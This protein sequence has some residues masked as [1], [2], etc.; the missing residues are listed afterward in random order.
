MTYSEI[1]QDACPG[2]ISDKGKGGTNPPIFTSKPIIPYT[3]SLCRIRHC[4][5]QLE[6]FVE[7][8]EPANKLSE[9]INVLTKL[10]KKCFSCTSLYQLY[11]EGLNLLKRLGGRSELEKFWS[12]LSDY[13]FKDTRSKLITEKGWPIVLITGSSFAQ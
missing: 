11:S 3:N 8:Q 6:Y 4:E 13:L 2:H 10:R 9:E 12:E 5:Y 7:I 1:E